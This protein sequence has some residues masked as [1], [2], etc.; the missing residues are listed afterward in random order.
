VTQL[1]RMMLDELERRNYSPTTVH[2]YI[3]AIKDL[4]L[5]FKCPP[6]QLSPAQIRAYQAYLFR[7]R[8]LDAGTV[9]Q[10]TAAMRFFF[11]A[12]LKKKWSLEDIPYPRKA[13]RLPKGHQPGAGGQ[14][15]RLSQQCV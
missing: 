12:T 10:K 2:A 4:A 15:D 6:D 14:A 11:L 9:T 8:K 3:Q 13:R 1:R 7:E 5:Y